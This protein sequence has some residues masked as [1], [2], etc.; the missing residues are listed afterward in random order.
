MINGF[1]VCLTRPRRGRPTTWLGL[2]SLFTSPHANW[3][4]ILSWFHTE[5]HINTHSIHMVPNVVV[6]EVR[7]PNYGLYDSPAPHDKMPISPNPR[8]LCVYKTPW[9]SEKAHTWRVWLFLSAHLWWHIKILAPIFHIHTA[10]EAEDKTR[11]QMSVSR[12][13]MI[14][15]TRNSE[16]KKR[17]WK[18]ISIK[19][20]NLSSA[21]GV[22]GMWTKWK[23]PRERILDIARNENSGENRPKR[24]Q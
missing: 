19:Y 24:I 8:V 13:A 15:G 18:T 1:S 12:V 3:L 20:S 2:K 22:K 14:G 6:S 10:R 21:R 16:A 7:F 17:R 9:L 4:S 23:I 11:V 5:T